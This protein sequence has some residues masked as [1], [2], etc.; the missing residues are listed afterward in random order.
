MWI[1]AEQLSHFY[2]SPLGQGVQ[3]YILKVI[4]KIWTNT[5]HDVVV[6]YGFTSPFL[7]LFRGEA[8]RTIAMMPAP[9]GAIHWPRGRSN[10]TVLVEETLWPLADGSV[11]RLLLA[12]CIEFSDHLDELL[13]EAWRV[14]KPEG[15]IL[16][17]APNRRGIWS[18]FTKSPLGYGRPYT[19]HQLFAILERAGF[20]PDKPKYGLYMPPSRRVLMR[21]FAGTFEKLGH[22]FWKK[23][24][25]VVM[26]CAK[27][28]IHGL[29][30]PK[31]VSGGVKIFKP[32][33]SNSISG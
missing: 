18:Q 16:V 13:Q 17:I 19:G 28:R 1:D 21:R 31:P 27:K 12:H 20:V 4:N 3:K 32:Q 22:R 8:D 23:F 10:A 25:G 26:C 2:S 15:E 24:G 14:L 11:D 7:D 6:G 30:A 5:R 29:R 9:Q 33:T